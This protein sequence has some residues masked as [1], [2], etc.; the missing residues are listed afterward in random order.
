MRDGG[1]RHLCRL[2]ISLLWRYRS[3]LD[4]RTF[5][6]YVELDLFPDF[7]AIKQGSGRG[8]ECHRHGGP[9]NGGNGVVL[10]GQ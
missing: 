3:D 5:D 9:I 1:G 10:D 2:W 8:L 7:K 4:V 6:G